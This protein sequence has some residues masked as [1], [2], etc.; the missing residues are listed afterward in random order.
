V[1]IPLILL[2]IVLSLA[3]PVFFTALNIRNLLLQSAIVGILAFG[4]TIV[5]ITEE[6]DLSIGAVEGLAAVV[7]AV[8]IVDHGVPW[9]LGIIIALGVGIGI[10]L[11]NGVITV[12]VGVPSFITT[13][14]MLGLATGF[15]QKISN[16]ETLTGF[17]DHYQFLGRQEV[18]FHV[19]LPVFVAAAVLVVLY[20]ILRH[21]RLGLN[22]YAVGGNRRAASLAGLRPG[23]VKMIALCIS[24][25][26]AALGGVLLSA[27]LDAAASTYGANDLLNAIAA[28]VIGGTALTGGVGSVIGT[29]FGVLIIVSIQNGLILLNVSPLWTQAFVGGIILLAAVIHRLGTGER[30]A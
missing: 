5:L 21:T 26:C 13:L 20:L 4:A 10:G 19:R 14:G 1:L 16:G 18:I 8:V 12:V 29:A 11:A 3:S 9:W 24:G 27:R 17:P 25:F 15:A 6:I 28:V 22:F 30:T 23:R 2:W 7:A